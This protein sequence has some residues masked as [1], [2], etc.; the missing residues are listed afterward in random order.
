MY[1][2]VMLILISINDEY[3]QNVVFSSEK[4]SNSQDYSSSDSHNPI[5]NFLCS[6]IFN[7]PHLGEFPPT[8][9]HCLVKA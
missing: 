8:P 9:K 7:C 2:N 5:K 1:I 4:G 3:L 6:K